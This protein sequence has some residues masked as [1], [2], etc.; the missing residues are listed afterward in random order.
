MGTSPAIYLTRSLYSVKRAGAHTHTRAFAQESGG[1]QI[2]NV[3]SKACRPGGPASADASG[4]ETLARVTAWLGEGGKTKAEATGVG[5]GFAVFCR[6]CG[7]G[8]PVAMHRHEITGPLAAALDVK[9]KLR[10]HVALV[11][12][13]QGDSNPAA[14]AQAISGSGINEVRFRMRAK[15]RL[16]RNIR[17][18]LSTFRSDWRGR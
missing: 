15:M 7:T 13:W 2:R 10:A 17:M 12:H 3:Q 9:E 18:Y 14:I 16:R 6:A 5:S 8:T 1:S 11:S 4:P